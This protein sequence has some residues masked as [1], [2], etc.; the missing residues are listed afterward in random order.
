MDFF[1]RADFQWDITPGDFYFPE[2]TALFYFY[3]KGRRKSDPFI[4]IGGQRVHQKEKKESDPKGYLIIEGTLP[5]SDKSKTLMT[6]LLN[7]DEQIAK[8]GWSSRF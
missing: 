1:V 6:V 7:A 2:L 5:V 4:G 8:M 3:P